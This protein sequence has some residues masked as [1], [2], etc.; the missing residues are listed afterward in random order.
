MRSMLSVLRSFAGSVWPRRGLAAGLSVL[1]LALAGGELLAQQPGNNPP[2]QNIQKAAIGP[3]GNQQN[4]NPLFAG[5][6]SNLGQIEQRQRRS[7][8]CRFRFADR[9]DRSRRLPTKPGQRTAA[10]RRRFGRFP[11]ACWSMRAECCGSKRRPIQRR[12]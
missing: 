8:E 9:S 1:I 12:F 3:V 7:G 10:A 6:N 11:A 5:P 4:Q 2:G